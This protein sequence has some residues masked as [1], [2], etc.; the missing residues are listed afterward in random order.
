MT[1]YFSTHHTTSHNP[2]TQ[3]G[4]TEGTR[5]LPSLL[6][7][8]SVFNKLPNSTYFPPKY[9]SLPSCFPLETTSLSLFRPLGL[10]HPDFCNSL[11]TSHLVPK[12]C[13][14]EQSECLCIVTMFLLLIKHFR[15]ILSGL[16]KVPTCHVAS[17]IQSPLNSHWPTVRVLNFFSLYFEFL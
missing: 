15:S 9:S 4:T 13:S 3:V 1:C 16:E 10:S 8:I 7:F 6:F 11:S 12:T 2:V 17:G 14:E 5:A